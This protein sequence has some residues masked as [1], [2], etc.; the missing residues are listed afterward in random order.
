[1]GQRQ[2]GQTICVS[3]RRRRSIGGP[4]AWHT[5]LARFGTIMKP[6]RL[7]MTSLS[8]RRSTSA[9]LGVGS[10]RRADQNRSLGGVAAD[11]RG[12]DRTDLLPTFTGHAACTPDWPRGQTYVTLGLP[13]R[14]IAADECPGTARDN[15]Q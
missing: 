11:G 5:E 10:A 13:S 15:L 1:M 4:S 2:C 3:A 7:A 6:S 14:N 12:K 9:Q 8:K